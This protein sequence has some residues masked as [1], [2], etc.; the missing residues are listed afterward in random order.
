M[1]GVI[2]ASG[3][4]ISG[5]SEYNADSPII[6]YN[7]VVTSANLTSFS[8]EA[9]HP[10][11]NIA[12]PATHLYWRSGM[13]S[14]SSTEWIRVNINSVG[15]QDYLAIA[16]HNFG[17]AQIPI[18]VYAY[19]A[20][21]GWEELIPAT[22]PVDDGPIILRWNA[23]VFDD[24]YFEVHESPV[25]ISPTLAVL[26]VGELLKLQ[27]RIYVGH[28]P[29]TY[30]RRLNVANHRSVSG[31]FL[32]RIVLGQ[33]N[34]C[35]VALNNLTPS[36]FRSMLWPFLLAAEEIPFFFAWRP[37]TYSDECGYVW[38]TG[39]PSPTNAQGN[40]MMSVNLDMEGVV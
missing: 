33:K 27:R 9:E 8:E 24:I 6:G 14:P 19:T 18:R 7:N 28:Q 37:S 39:D 16:G 30:N 26:Y 23:N 17:T 36:W 21:R 35:T 40:G 29:V 11:I 15:V 31:A 12:N 13:G 2:S 34:G 3:L 1:T 38:L 25:G 10:L 5:G 22:T 4:V 32:G 20:S